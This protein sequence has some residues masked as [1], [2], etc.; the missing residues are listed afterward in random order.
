MPDIEP[1]AAPAHDSL[2]HG[3]ASPSAGDEADP[4]EFDAAGPLA[5]LCGAA[6]LAVLAL[7]AASLML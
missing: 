1:T 3:A 4:S 7:A 6:A 5:R 2:A